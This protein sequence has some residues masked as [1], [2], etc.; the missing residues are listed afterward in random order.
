MSADADRFA[1]SV[2]EHLTR[3]R[4]RLAFDLCRPTRKVLKVLNDARQIDVS[5][6]LNWLA[7]ISGF[8]LGKL[9]RIAFDQLRQFEEQTPAIARAHLCPLSGHSFVRR[10]DS[11]IDIGLI[12]F[13]YF[14]ERL[15]CSRV[16]RFEYLPRFRINK[17]PV[18]EQLVAAWR[19]LDWLW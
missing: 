3:N 16:R 10:G 11:Y 12:G 18:D 6:F 9:R 13:S 19:G 5:R 14:S 8:Q 1:Q 7:V 15:T 4:N 2:I 17:L